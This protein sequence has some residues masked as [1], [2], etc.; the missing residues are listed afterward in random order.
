MKSH[1]SRNLD[2]IELEVGLH[3]FQL[4]RQANSVTLQH[5]HPAFLGNEFETS[6]TTFC[7]GFN[8]IILVLQK[9]M[10][11]ECGFLFWLKYFLQTNSINIKSKLYYLSVVPT[12]K[13]ENAPEGP[14]QKRLREAREQSKCKAKAKVNTK[15]WFL[16]PL[17]RN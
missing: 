14:T 5:Y 17:I 12:C 8:I 15:V 4:A 2:I 16:F 13:K 7:Y 9:Y 10:C 1:E 11:D 3:A 6:L